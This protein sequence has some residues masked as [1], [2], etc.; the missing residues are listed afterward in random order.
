MDWPS[1]VQ[2]QSLGKKATRPSLISVRLGSPP[3]TSG[4]SH[5]LRMKV[6]LQTRLL[7]LNLRKAA[8]PYPQ[9]L[10]PPL[11]H[12][13]GLA[14]GPAQGCCQKNYFISV[15]WPLSAPQ[16]PPSCDSS[17]NGKLL[18]GPNDF[19]KWGLKGR[20]QSGQNGKEA[21]ASTPAHSLDQEGQA[22]EQEKGPGRGSRPDPASHPGPGRHRPMCH[23]QLL[24]EPGLA[25]GLEVADDN[26]ELPDVL[27]EL[28]QVLLQ[29]VELLRHR[30]AARTPPRPSSCP[31]ASCFRPGPPPLPLPLGAGWGGAA[32]V[33]RGRRGGVWGVVRSRG[34]ALGGATGAG[35]S[36]LGPAS[37][38]LCPPGERRAARV[39]PQD[40]QAWLRDTQS[41]RWRPLGSRSVSPGP[42]QVR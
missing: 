24:V 21:A 3:R 25:A 39:G 10:T 28:L 4:W 26:A 2:P 17:S 7:Y 38:S 36:Q 42:E 27:H 11:V 41:Q 6:G 12:P 15:P 20:S 37:A 31:T 18:S 23:S 13:R 34:G 5:S 22:P 35:R 14:P 40:L 16:H 29:V 8:S 30:R 32:G 1:R 33:G 19:S 9:H